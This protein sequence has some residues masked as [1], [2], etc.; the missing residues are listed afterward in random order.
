MIT[1][2]HLITEITAPIQEVFNLSRN[3]DFHIQ[4]AKKTNEKA[5]SGVTQGL[6]NLN[7]TVTWKGKHFGI[8]L[9]HQSKITELDFPNSF[10]DE[11]IKGHFKSFKHQH[12]FSKTALGTKMIDILEYQTPYGYIGKIFNGL[13]LKRHL[14][15][16]L[17]TRN[18]SIKTHI[19]T[20]KR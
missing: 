17:T 16:F 4:S 3:I 14:F 11:M 18:E 1:K 2:L 12:H 6:I 8:Y 5:I 20:K 10:T 15:N 9:T 7:E 13:C 19:E